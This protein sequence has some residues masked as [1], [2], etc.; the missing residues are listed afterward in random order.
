MFYN[1]AIG[2]VDYG[3]MAAD[4]SQQLQMINHRLNSGVEIAFDELDV[5]RASTPNFYAISELPADVMVEAMLT[6]FEFT[7][8]FN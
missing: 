6:R 7:A 1:L 4:A 8:F 5:L 2:I 3:L